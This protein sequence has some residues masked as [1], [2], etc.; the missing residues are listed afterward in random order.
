M[1]LLLVEDDQA[2]LNMYK[3]TLEEGKYEVITASDGVSALDMALDQ[4]PDL[5]LLDLSLPKLN[6]LD[7]M[8]KLREDSWGAKVPII[9]LTNT[10]P[11][12]TILDA[13]SKGNPSYYLI[14]SNVTPEGIIL[15]IKEVLKL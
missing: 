11:D 1:K 15:K 2:L 3:E 8:D 13:V 6:G 4:H 9:I 7:V 12:N 5:I 14:K 10:D